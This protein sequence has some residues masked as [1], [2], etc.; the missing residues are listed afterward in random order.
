[1]WQVATRPPFIP[2]E[3][4]SFARA[5]MERRSKL[6]V[7]AVPMSEATNEN[8]YSNACNLYSSDNAR[9]RDRDG[10]RRNGCA[11]KQGGNGDSRLFEA[12]LA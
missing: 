7:A 2:G 5:V 4:V 3:L 11:L 8:S 9:H 12:S 10:R 6:I 1:M